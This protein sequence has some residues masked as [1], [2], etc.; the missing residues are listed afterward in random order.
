MN[1][2]LIGIQGCGKG[3]LVAGLEKHLDFSLVSAGQL[4]RDEVATGS[5]LGQRIKSLQDKGILVDFDIVMS[6]LNKKLNENDKPIMIFDGFPRNK[7]QAEGIDKILNIDL[8]IYLNLPKEV[9]VSRIVNRLTC[10][11]CGYIT[12]KQDV[13]TDVCVKCGGKLAQRSDD[14]IEAV[15]KRFEIYE[16]DTYPLIE[17]YKARGVVAEIDANRTPNEVLEDVMK[18]I[19]ERNNQR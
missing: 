16:K 5:E 10:S 17:R 2:V 13:T 6:L 12:K 4:L 8:V 15:N 9:A 1:I 11:K 14:T 3:T 7:E 18:V 19:N